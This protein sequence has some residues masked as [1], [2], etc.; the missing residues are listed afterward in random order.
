M[1]TIYK[2]LKVTNDACFNVPID[3]ALQSIKEGKSKHIVGLVRKEKDPV[4]K[5]EIKETLP[6]ICF[7]WYFFAQG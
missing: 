3:Y 5:K 2:K 1:I 7:S 6:S 4:K